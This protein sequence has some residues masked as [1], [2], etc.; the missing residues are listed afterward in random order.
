MEDKKIKKI[1][2]IPFVKYTEV[3]INGEKHHEPKEN[4]TKNDIDY[5][6]IAGY[7]PVFMSCENNVFTLSEL[8]LHFNRGNSIKGFIYYLYDDLSDE[9]KFLF[10]DKTQ[11]I[12]L[13]VE[14]TK[15]EKSSVTKKTKRKRFE[16]S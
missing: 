1:L 6:E 5:L 12:D 15:E 9:D 4:L 3:I 14:E 13:Y 7:K 8:P 16:R 11:E 10:S 2:V